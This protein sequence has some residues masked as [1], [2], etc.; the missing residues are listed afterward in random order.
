MVHDLVTL[1]DL[2]RRISDNM[3]DRHI[4]AIRSGNATESRELTRAVRC[5]EGANAIADAGIAVCSICSVQLVGISLP[6]KTSFRDEVEKC[7]L[8]V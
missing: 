4:L 3:Q 6:L 1:H 7:E 8:V 2:H 5:Y